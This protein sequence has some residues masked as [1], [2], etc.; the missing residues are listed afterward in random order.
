VLAAIKTPAFTVNSALTSVMNQA[1]GATSGVNAA[2]QGL[3]LLSCYNINNVLG[4]QSTRP[5]Q[6]PGL[7]TSLGL[8][9]GLV[10][11][12][13]SAPSKLIAS[14]TNTITNSVNQVL[15]SGEKNIRGVLD[16]VSTGSTQVMAG[17]DDA[18]DEITR[19]YLNAPISEYAQYLDVAPTAPT[20]LGEFFG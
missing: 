1:V 2:N 14:A 15:A 10:N 9:V 7:P 19:A 18:G 3:N 4:G 17:S 8:P 11:S 16:S 13:I 20:D 5:F 12:V 6:V